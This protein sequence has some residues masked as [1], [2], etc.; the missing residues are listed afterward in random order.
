MNIVSDEDVEWLESHKFMHDEQLDAWS[1]ELE[2]VSCVNAERGVVHQKIQSA[3]LNVLC[4]GC[5]GWRAQVLINNGYDLD[6]CS[7]QTSYVV[8]RNGKQ[9]LRRTPREAIA[10]AADDLTA[11]LMSCLQQAMKLGTQKMK[12]DNTQQ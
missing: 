3:Y 11:R 9:R 6:G 8:A 5:S 12:Q 1:R 4:D 2:V 7:R 10:V